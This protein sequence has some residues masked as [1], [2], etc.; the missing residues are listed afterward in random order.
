MSSEEKAI[1]ASIFAQHLHFI[2]DETAWS[3]DCYRD[4]GADGAHSA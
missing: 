3:T 1:V 4:G 2:R